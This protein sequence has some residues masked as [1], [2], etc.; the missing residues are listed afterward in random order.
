M[1]HFWITGDWNVPA[2]TVG[3]RWGP[4]IDSMIV[5][6]YIDGERQ[7][8]L[9]F[10]PALACGVG[11]FAQGRPEGNEAPKGALPHAWGSSLFGKNAAKGGWWFNVPIPFYK[12]VRVTLAAPQGPDALRREGQS[13][14]AEQVYIMVRGT[15]QRRISVG[16][17]V[18][19]VGVRLQLQK[20]V[21]RSVGEL[22]YV[23]LASVKR[24]RGTMLLTTLAVSSTAEGFLEGCFHRYSPYN[25]AF[26]GMLLGTGTEDYFN[27]AYYF[28][29]GMFAMANTG[30]TWFEFEG[31]NAAPPTLRCCSVF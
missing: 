9:E 6:Y 28:N 29:A 3:H 7:P 24:G 23:T 5:R 30:V 26:P 14:T 11:Q 25:Q 13:V 31:V 10:E 20:I 17:T 1:T 12:S 4:A 15:E 18:L 21:H 16:E 27:S 8:S 19:P 22:E 2:S